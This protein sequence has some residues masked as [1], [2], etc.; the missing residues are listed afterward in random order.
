MVRPQCCRRTTQ[1]RFHPKKDQG[2]TIRQF[3]DRLG[4]EKHSSQSKARYQPKTMTYTHKKFVD[5]PT[6]IQ[7]TI[8]LQF[9]NQESSW[10]K[11]TTYVGTAN[12]TANLSKKGQPYKR[13]KK[14]DK[15]IFLDSKHDKTRETR[16]ISSYKLAHLN[17]FQKEKQSGLR[18]KFHY[19]SFLTEK[20]SNHELD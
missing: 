5:Y 7:K 3:F 2:S 1:V 6:K 18:S 16:V 20:T 15:E 9:I 13:K 8:P 12:A 4:I 14:T 17:D 10:N 11:D 19:C